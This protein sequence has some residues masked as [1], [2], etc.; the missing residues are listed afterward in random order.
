MKNKKFTIGLALLISGSLFL[1]NCTKDKT[2]PAPEP[3]TDT[4]AVKD[5]IEAQIIV[6]DIG[7]IFAQTCEGFGYLLGTHSYAP[8]SKMDGTL[9]INSTSAFISRNPNMVGGR[10]FKLAFPTTIGKDG[11]VRM[12]LPNDSIVFDYSGTTLP[13]GMPAEYT[14][15]AGFS[16]NVKGQSG[17]PATLIVDNYTV[18]INSM[19]FFNSTA[20]GFP[21]TSPHLPANENL[22]WTQTSNVTITRPATATTPTSTITYIGTMTK[23]LLNTNNT[24]V[25]MPTPMAYQTFTVYPKPYDSNLYWD[26]A[27]ESFSG[28][29]EGMTSTGEAYMLDIPASTPLIR[30]FNNSP[31]KFIAIGGTLT[32]PELHPF[33]SGTLTV[34]PG[35]K[36]IRT[37]GFGDP[38]LV[39]Y[40]STVNIDGI[41]YSIDF[42]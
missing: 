22:T 30:N 9:T 28:K 4:Q 21:L 8:L 6:N 23:T 5:V 38:T 35:S 13:T 11:K 3:D 40:N 31:E 2:N 15:Q 16:V 34:K 7:E 42:K 25:P 39:D 18:V 20:I 29:A 19:S 33:V 1:T 17:G 12:T 10:Y 32:S 37:V 14:R 24:S 36:S 26:K 41:N 27:Y